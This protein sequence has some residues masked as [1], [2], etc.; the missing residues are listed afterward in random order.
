[1]RLEHVRR[2]VAFGAHPDDVEVGAGGLVAKLTN[3]G[4]H[5][6][7]VVTSI[8]N[9]YAVRRA[10]AT[11]SAA[12]LGAALVLPPGDETGSRIEDVPMSALVARFERELASVEP[13]LVIVHGSHDSHHD[14]IAVHRAVLAALRRTR[15][16]ILAFATRLPAGAAPPPPTCVVDISST[17]EQ[18]LAAVA[19][20]KSQ[21]S[22]D[23]P[24][25]RRDIHRALGITHGMQYA[26]VYEVLRIEL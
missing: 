22:A 18:K 21:F 23:F 14:H 10:E 24:E 1:M 8:P 19:E 13:D 12:K 5:V 4:A 11:A 6:A 25:K 7:I 15:C 2:A 9:Q 17:I 20:H 3:G 16:D 26:E